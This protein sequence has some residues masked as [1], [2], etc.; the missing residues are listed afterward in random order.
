MA[1]DSKT[2]G[3]TLTRERSRLDRI[4][5]RRRK[6]DWQYW[7]DTND[8]Q[9]YLDASAA[10]TYIRSRP[11]I[12]DE[13]LIAWGLAQ[14]KATDGA[15]TTIDVLYGE[16][17]DLQWKYNIGDQELEAVLLPSQSS[18]TDRTTQM[19]FLNTLQANSSWLPGNFDIRPQTIRILRKAGLSGLLLTNLYSQSGYWSKMGNEQHLRH[20]DSGELV[21]S[22]LCYQYRCGWDTGVSFIHSIRTR[23]RTTYFC[24]NFPSYA[25]E[26]LKA[27]IKSQPSV[28]Y[29]DFFL[30]ALVADDSLKQWQ[31]EI[32]HRRDALQ[33]FEKQYEDE[34]IDFHSSTI[35]LHR[36]SRHWLTLGQDCMDFHVQLKFLSE[37]Y[38][39]YTK[40]VSAQKPAW[41]HDKAVNMYESFGTLISQCDICMRWT[42][43]YHERT[44]LRINLLFHL[45]NQRESRTNTEIA[46]STAKVAEQ[47]QRDSA[48]MITI[49]AV[50]MI[51]LPGTF[52]SAILSTTFFDYDENGLSVSGKWWILMAATIPLTVVVFA[53]WWY[54]RYVK[55]QEKRP[56]VST[57]SSVAF[58]SSTELGLRK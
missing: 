14:A 50:T 15:Q 41:N 16:G 5:S 53:V 55:L 2:F 38:I 24:I 48:S 47:T 52:V 51:F 34:H 57:K 36:L 35:Q 21:S 25:L 27:V 33:I 45:A 19:C 26:R 20:D 54:W 12:E 4:D 23:H 40:A 37:A 1:M 39:S 17:V 31:F 7:P 3:V 56:Q 18:S 8:Q 49:A 28:A 32:S 43:Q 6:I 29:R 22:E 46:A 11:D 30:D 13:S 44:N 10:E 9:K 42:R 58:A